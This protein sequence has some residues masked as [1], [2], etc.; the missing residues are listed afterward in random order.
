MP[1]AT[2]RFA[3]SLLD[4]SFPPAIKVSISVISVPN[5]FANAPPSLAP[6]TPKALVPSPAPS[7]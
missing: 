5:L 6:I 1:P 4:P 2:I 7:A 3:T